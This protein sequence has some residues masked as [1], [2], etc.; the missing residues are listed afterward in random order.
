[1]GRARM[2]LDE[3]KR[4]VLEESLDVLL[5]QEPYSVKGRIPGFGV[6]DKVIV[7]E[8]VPMAAVVIC[9]EKLDCV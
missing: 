2:A 9:S 7:G 6:R 3:I 4:V 1:M 8:G 5:L